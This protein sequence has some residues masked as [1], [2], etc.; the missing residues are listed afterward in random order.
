MRM[1]YINL[2]LLSATVLIC[3]SM[4]LFN[5]K[6]ALA[7]DIRDELDRYTILHDRQLVDRWLRGQHHNSFFQIDAAIS[8]GTRKLVGDIKNQTQ[9]TSAN[10]VVK[11][12]AV[13]NL[14]NQNLN[15]EKYVDL[16]LE[17][18]LPL[19]YIKIFNTRLLPSLFIGLNMSL[20][21]TISNFGD[22]TNPRA[23]IYMKKDM[24]TGVKS[25]VQL[26]ENQQL[27]VALYKLARADAKNTITALQIANDQGLFDFDTLNQNQDLLA[28]DAVYKLQNRENI[29]HL[30][31]L[32]AGIYTMDFQR[33]SYYGT[34]PMTLAT[35]SRELKG[36]NHAWLVQAGHHY[37]RRYAMADGLFAH[38]EVSWKERLP[39]IGFF[40]VDPGFLTLGPIVRGRYFQFSY[41]YKTPY[42]NPQDRL[43]VPAIHNILLD[44]R[45]PL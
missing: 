14:L 17:A 18:G 9:D 2:F 45:F 36:R 6:H 10:P 3:L 19:P 39:L 33:R 28:L 30:G 12:L 1:R 16:D 20:S 44:I 26:R 15:T 27:E 24:K 4:N 8:S 25:V 40:K 35:W 22:A 29:Y 43:W 42:I 32:E 7:A 23:Q 31:F 38:A 11:A 41:L 13:A 5:P 34:R 37:R 21:L